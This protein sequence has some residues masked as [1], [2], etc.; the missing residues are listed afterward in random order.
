MRAPSQGAR[1]RPINAVAPSAGQDWDSERY[2]RNA[3]FVSTLGEDLLALLDARPGERIL[4]LGCGD[5]VLTAKIAAAG[6]NVLGIDAS[7][8]QI[9][10]ARRLGVEARTADAQALSFDPEFDAVFSN[11]ALHWM[12]QPDAVIAGVRRALRPGGRFVAE[13]GGHGNVGAVR[14]ALGAALARRG[15]DAGLHDPWYF[16][17][18]EDYRGRLQA[19]GFVVETISDFARPT[20]LP[21]A[22]VDWLE[23]FAGAFLAAVNPNERRAVLAETAAALEPSLKNADGSWWVDYVRLRFHAVKP[24]GGS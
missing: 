6:A 7:A 24:A 1:G 20:V 9:A 4:D 21:G 19:G 11:A 23:T 16:P 5:G 14:T 18:V 2:A 17:T 8:A 22:M 12:K 10:A 3:R 13:M 15:I